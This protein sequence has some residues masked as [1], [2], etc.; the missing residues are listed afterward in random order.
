MKRLLCLLLLPTLALYAQG[1][2]NKKAD[3]P[4]GPQIVNLGEAKL[5]GEISGER[6]SDPEKQSDW[7]SVA[8]AAD[9]SFYAVYV[10]WNDKDADSMVVRRK[11]PSGKWEAPV[12]INDGDW[13]HYSPTI[14]ARG[15]GAMA[16][17]SGQAR[18]ASTCCGR[19]LTQRRSI[20]TRAAHQRAVQRLQCS[21]CCGRLRR[22]DRG[23][24]IVSQRQRRHLRAPPHRQRS[25]APETRI[26][27]SDANDWE[28]SIAL[29]RRGV[30]WIS[31]DS[32]QTGNYDVF[33]RSF[34]GKQLGETDRHHDRA[35]GAVSHLRRGGWRG[36]RLGGLGRRRP[37]LG[38]GF[39][40]QQLGARQPRTALFAQDRD[41]RL[42]Q[43]PR[44]ESVRR[45]LA[46]SHE[47]PHD[48]LC[49]AAA[50]GLRR[51]GALC[52]VFRHWTYPSRTRSIISMSR[53]LSG[54]AWTQPSKLSLSSG[55]NT[56]HAA[57]T[58]TPDGRAFRVGYAS[59]GR[60]ATNLPTDQMHALHYNVYVSAL[61]KGEGPP[62]VTTFSD[63]SLPAPSKRRPAT[64]ARHHDRRRQDLSSAD[65]RR[66]SP[67]RHP[68]P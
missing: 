11:D 28:P 45:C 15:A 43:R 13:D 23:L 31:W 38:Q 44:A 52:M 16:I 67:H 14:V 66:P 5:A 6:V 61:P 50:P 39:F 10:E 57:L 48:P 18:M 34:D 41:A 49:G 63:V 51:K 56:Q 4:E 36:P 60:S 29:D 20:Q 53:R 2:K 1:K 62:K 26:S 3:N 47:R 24:A 12:T 35:F 42:R 64:A 46:Q 21:R 54:D 22:G 8:A 37:E 7:P 55:Q 30:A 33:L 25:G 27:T 58:M 32:Y 40:G 19:N 65:G 68:R 17:W 9:G 59:D